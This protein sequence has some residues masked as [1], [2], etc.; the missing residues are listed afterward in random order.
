MN[1]VNS[2]NGFFPDE[3]ILHI[4]ARLPIKSLF[5][6]R[7]V[8]K[9]W[10]QLLSDKYFVHLFNEMSAK[11]SMILVEITEV[12][13]FKSSLICVDYLRGVS[14][15]PL[16]FLKD[17]VKVRASCNGLLCCSS[18]PDKGVFYVCN[19]MTREFKL[20]PKTR[21]RPV[22]RFYPDGEATLV[23]IACNLSD[24]SKFNVVLAGYHR[25]FGYS[26][27]KTF[28]CMVYDSDVNKWRKFVTLQEEHFTQMNR[29][30][31]VFV[32]GML[33]WLT[34]SYSC[35]LVLDLEVDVWRKIY[36]PDKMS[37]GTG[38]RMYL[39]ESNGC[40]SLM[41]I[42]DA[43]M[44]IWVLEDYEKQDWRMVDRVSLRCIRGLG[45][46]IFPISQTGECV[47][48]ATHKQV[49]VYNR[50]TAVWKE[51]FAVKSNSALPL[52]FS[53]YAFR[54]TIFSFH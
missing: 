18:I 47:F 19:P 22:T 7:T 50:S 33:H 3:V 5:R 8:C 10:Y 52:W 40:L 39:L 42:S 54:S 29:N 20:L 24:N 30:Q 16:D 43:W 4:L 51:M 31:V 45:P 1:S 48:L 14:E 53:A 17:R 32:N 28:I 41:Q 38:N 9:Y 15:F 49:L 27:T 13:E 44:D 2:T 25:P 36:L 6:F 35:I 23:G 46:G 37:S 11:S 21:E 12:S 26:P 34:V